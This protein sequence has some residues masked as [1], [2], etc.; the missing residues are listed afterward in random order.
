[1]KQKIKGFRLINIAMKQKILVSFSG[2]ETSAYM[3]KMLKDKFSD[4]YDIFFVFANTGKEREE[5]LIFANKCDKEFNLNLVW[6]EAET[7][8]QK[9]KGVNAKIVNF[10]TASRNGEPFYDMIKK[11]GIPN[12]QMAICTRE[13]KDYAIRSYCR[14]IG[15]KKS[16]YKIAIGI[17]ADEIDRI[18]SKHK[19]KGFVYPLI[20]SNI[21]KAQINKFWSEMPFRLDLK[22]YEGNCDFCFKKSDRKLLTIAKENPK[23]VEWWN[24]I[25]K[26]FG[27]YNPRNSEKLPFSFFR[28]N[29]NAEYFIEHSYDNFRL[30]IDEKL[31]TV[32]T[33]SLFDEL[34][35]SGSCEESCLAFNY[36]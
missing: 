1:M 36:L 22:S 33:K 14:K 9:G 13:L 29:R 7:N 24:N 5:T 26:E 28:N 32:Y 31:N 21:I 10:E 12:I 34:D 30:S 25:E 20:E 8:P 15:L 4:V 11:H 35:K 18:N 3:A 2:G 27:Y 23:I 6:V 17:R 16:D 19:E